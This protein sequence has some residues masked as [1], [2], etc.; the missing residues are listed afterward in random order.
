MTLFMEDIIM[1]STEILF[2]V[3]EDDKLDFVSWSLSSVKGTKDVS[4]FSLC[5]D[6]VNDFPNMA[7]VSCSNRDDLTIKLFQD[8]PGFTLVNF[9][10]PGVIVLPRFYQAARVVL[11]ATKR[12][13]CFC[14]LFE[15]NESG[16]EL[17]KIPLVND[18]FC[19]SQFVV[20]RWVLEELGMMG[21]EEMFRKIIQ[22]YRGYE[23]P[24]VFCTRMK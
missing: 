20:R 8:N 3:V 13:Y 10:Y 14:H 17:I 6:K 16:N 1:Y 9:L 22:D 7:R 15:V 12:D 4:F 24:T 18:N 2:P 23:I 5:D 19:P 21:V 11:E